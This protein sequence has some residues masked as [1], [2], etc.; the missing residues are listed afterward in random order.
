MALATW[1]ATVQDDNGNV[2][3][4]PVVTVRVGGS[5]G[6]LADVKRSD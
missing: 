1:Q 5:G 2:I 6:A 4:N 3:V